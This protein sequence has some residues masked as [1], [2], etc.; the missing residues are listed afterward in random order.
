M[1]VIFYSGSNK[2]AE[3]NILTEDGKLLRQIKDTCDHGLNFYDYDLS[4]DSTKADF[5]KKY[6]KEKLKGQK[7]SDK[8]EVSFEKTDS[9]K[10]YLRP[11]KYKLEIEIDGIKDIHTFEITPPRKSPRE[12]KELMP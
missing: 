2:I 5:Y 9:G 7:D 10:T 1:N 4:I 12:K 3:I 11:G 6:V 8:S